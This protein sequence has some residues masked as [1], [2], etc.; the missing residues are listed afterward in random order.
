VRKDVEG[1]VVPVDP[2]SVVP[3]FLGLLNWHVCSLEYGH[4]QFE[5]TVGVKER[6][7]ETLDE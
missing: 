3:D 6:Q 4:S 7:S 2:L 5:N 1:G